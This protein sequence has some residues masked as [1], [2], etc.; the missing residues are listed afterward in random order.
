MVEN[1]HL[2]ERDQNFAKGLE[3][4]K[5]AAGDAALRLAPSYDSIQ[6]EPCL[7]KKQSHWLVQRDPTSVQ[8]SYQSPS[9]LLVAI[10]CL[11]N[12]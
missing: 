10:Y 4:H 2:N 9:F 12:E 6:N 11:H 1:R 5:E 8:A 7:F 3:L